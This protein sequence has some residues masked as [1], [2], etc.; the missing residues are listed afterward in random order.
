[1]DR[2]SQSYQ[3]PVR[4]STPSVA[5]L[6]ET[7]RQSRHARRRKQRTTRAVSTVVLV[8]AVIAAIVG[9]YAYYQSLP[10][11]II[12]NGVEQTL[13]AGTTI[14][15]IVDQGLVQVRQKGDLL[16]V[17]GSLIEQG[18]GESYTVTINGEL[19]Q[20]NNVRLGNNDTV[21][22]IDALDVEEDSEIVETAI[23]FSFEKQGAGALACITQVGLD[24]VSR[25]KVGK[26]SGKRS[27]EIEEPVNAIVTYYNPQPTEKV[28]ALTFDDGP[29]P[30]TQQILDNL[31]AV[32]AK[33]TFFCL[34]T[35]ADAV[36]E[37]VNEM[38]VRGHQVASHSYWH[39]NLTSIS[40]AEVLSEWQKSE[41]AILT[42]SGV[43]TTVGRAPYGR[44]GLR[45]WQASKDA[46][47]LLVGWNID[48]HDW[49]ASDAQ[50]IADE[51]L[52][53]ASPGKIA[54]L[55]DG[56]ANR[57]KTAESLQI[58]LPKLVEQGYRF[59]TIDEL[60]EMCPPPQ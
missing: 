2:R 16:A 54:L 22:F 27:S 35:N 23:P 13:P 25:D 58:F 19:S 10:I 51:M 45:E 44:F 50:E 36:P 53:E 8:V 56:G 18:K 41:E 26:V 11:N 9:G 28:M 52:N 3:R 37:M 31:D 46:L 17:D 43:K 40:E 60:Y 7:R 6:S 21:V 47:S 57:S 5:M 14:G 49:N 59:V 42:A 48:S 12:V 39:N 30:S 55:H 32:G 24:G 29:G 20:A 1:M 38:V 15:D 4:G 34:G 33:A